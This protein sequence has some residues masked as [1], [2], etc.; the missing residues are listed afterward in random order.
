MKNYMEYR[1]CLS[2][3]VLHRNRVEK[4]PIFFE[5]LTR[6]YLGKLREWW[7]GYTLPDFKETNKAY[8]FYEMRNH[9]NIEFV[10]YNAL[11]ACEGF[12][13]VVYCSGENEA[14][15]RQVLGHN[16]DRA[17]VHV[18]FEKDIGREEGRK[19]YN[20]TLMSLDFWQGFPT[21]HILICET[22]AY[23]FRKLPADLLDYDYVGYE[24]QW[25][26]GEPGGGGVSLRKRSAM[27]RICKESTQPPTYGAD[28]WA[29]NGVKELGL[30]FKNAF[31]ESVFN[32]VDPIA[33]HQW[34][35]F[36]DYNEA[37]SPAFKI[38]C[39]CMLTLDI[40]I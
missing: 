5:V 10:L 37:D 12:G 18:L 26:P 22:D 6:R 3:E 29:S 8:L 2:D 20:E 21:E 38:I 14:L 13:L 24:W 36:I 31:M 28:T 39:I 35:S 34:W 27:V 32:L 25:L 1:Y 40:P 15:I 16:V 4:E 30:T 7:R 17:E 33:V 19:L 23:F 11:C 9:P